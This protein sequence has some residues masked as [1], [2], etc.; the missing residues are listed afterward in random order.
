MLKLVLPDSDALRPLNLLFADYI[1]ENKDKLMRD[2]CIEYVYGAPTQCIANGGRPTVN[3][4]P[5]Q[6]IQLLIA[7]YAMRGI[8]YRF[9]FSNST[10]TPSQFN[11]AQLNAIMKLNGDTGAIVYRDDFAVYLRASYPARHLVASVTK[12]A[13]VDSLL[14]MLNGNL[15]DVVVWSTEHNDKL[16]SVPPELR[17]KVEVLPIDCC[18]NNCPRRAICYKECSAFNN[19]AA[20]QFGITLNADPV[21]PG[22]YKWYTASHCKNNKVKVEIAQ[23]KSAYA[24][25]HSKD[26]F[27][28]VLGVEKI[29]E[30]VDNGF[31]RIKVEGRSMSTYEM[32]LNYVELVIKPEYQLQ[33]FFDLLCELN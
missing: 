6:I 5:L 32:L 9:V 31:E 1:A 2:T 7:D 11:D 20:D 21:A 24:R 22:V 3:N 12:M 23:L 14:R 13:D 26:T 10:I 8:G 25:V 27:N 18:P 28:G 15:Y 17:H 33:A 16:N 30:L 19:P 4:T 29:H